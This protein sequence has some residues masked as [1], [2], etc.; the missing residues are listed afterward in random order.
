M[1]ML[2]NAEKFQLYRQV[3]VLSTSE[4]EIPTKKFALFCRSVQ[5]SL[6]HLLGHPL[7]GH[8]LHGEA[9]ASGREA[10]DIAGVAEKLQERHLGVDHPHAAVDPAI[11]DHAALGQ[12]IPLD[13]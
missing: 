10:P 3:D 11:Q 1:T 13:R 4:K 5:N 7:I 6:R 12:Q 8:R 9:P 2:A